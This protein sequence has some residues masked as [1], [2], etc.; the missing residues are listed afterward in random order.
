MNYT[1]ISIELAAVKNYLCSV[2]NIGLS[3]KQQTDD[4]M[5]ALETSKSQRCVSVGLNLGVY[6][7]SHVKKQFHSSYKVQD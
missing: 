7:T 1:L 3:V 6:V 4:F 5:S 2:F